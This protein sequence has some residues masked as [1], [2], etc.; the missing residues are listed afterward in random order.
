VAKKQKVNRKKY[1]KNLA[2]DLILNYFKLLQENKFPEFEKD[3]TKEILKIS[4][5]FNIRLD[6]EKKL[7][8]CRK[9]FVF[10]RINRTLKIR[11]NSKF[12]TKDYICLNCGNIK[13]F[14]YK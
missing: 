8:F 2:F 1:Q 10:F 6:R 11:L 12:K 14:R 7:S 5:S 4:S 3:Y 13:R 9:C